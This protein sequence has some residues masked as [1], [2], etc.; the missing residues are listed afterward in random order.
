M[1]VLYHFPA[2]AP[3]RGALLTI[4]ALGIDADVQI[5]D[6]FKKEQ[7]NPDFVKVD[8]LFRLIMCY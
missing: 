3:S 8:V 1:V 5:I 6:L 4:K 2:S 7:L